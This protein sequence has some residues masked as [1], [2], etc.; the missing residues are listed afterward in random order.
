MAAPPTPFSHLLSA[1]PD[2]APTKYTTNPHQ[3][4]HT[5]THTHRRV[6]YGAAD[7]GH[8]GVPRAGRAHF[9]QARHGPDLRGPLPG[10]VCMYGWMYFDHIS[11]CRTSHPRSSPVQQQP[12]KCPPTF[13][14]AQVTSR[15]RRGSTSRRSSPWPRGTPSRCVT[16]RACI[17]LWMC[18]YDGMPTCGASTEEAGLMGFLLSVRTHTSPST[19]PSGP[20]TDRPTDHHPRPMH[21]CVCLHD[22]NQE[23]A[24]MLVRSMAAAR[25]FK[26]R[27]EAQVG[28]CFLCDSC[29]DGYVWGLGPPVRPWQRRRARTNG[30][31][32]ADWFAI[33]IHTYYKYPQNCRLSR[34]G[35]WRTTSTSTPTRR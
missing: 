27:V 7:G 1:L 19:R 5:H 21:M 13:R 23:C 12:P 3:P 14:H 2:S 33:C 34:R 29:T 11:M 15:P 6:H 32:G 28:P 31:R 4:T 8:A 10:R 22:I 35:R 17:R 24:D 20:Q 30:T 26:R 18:V 9:L 16:M 25:T